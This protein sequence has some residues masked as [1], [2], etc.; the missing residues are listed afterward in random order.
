MSKSTNTWG[1]I[2]Q[3]ILGGLAVIITSYLL[4]GVSVENFLT[5]VII[6]ALIALLN[7]TI[8]PILIILTIPITIV[9]LGLF[10]IV[11]NALLILL[12][13]KIVPGFTV[14]GFW[15]ALLFGLILGLINSLLGVS[16]GRSSRD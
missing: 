16:L 7:I 8:K 1:I 14:D 3:L 10:L 4:P 6:A 5:G 13:A 11:I 15:W 9:T 2:V 12:A